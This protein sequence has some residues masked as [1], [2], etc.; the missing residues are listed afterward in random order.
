M[1]SKKKFAKRI[2]PGPLPAEAHVQA[3]TAGF[4]AGAGSTIC[5]RVRLEKARLALPA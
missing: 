3:P 2:D 5:L 4:A 1:D